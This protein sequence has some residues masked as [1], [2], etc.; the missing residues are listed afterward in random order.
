MTFT[1]KQASGRSNIGIIRM[2]AITAFRRHGLVVGRVDHTTLASESGAH[3]PLDNLVARCNLAGRPMWDDVITEH[4]RT[5]VEATQVGNPADLPDEEFYPRLRERVLAPQ[6]LDQHREF[7]YNYLRPLIAAEP[8]GLQRGLCLS[9]PG[10]ALT[11][12]DSHVTP[13]DVEAAW[14]TGR[15]NTA[16][17]TFDTFEALFKD[18]VHVAVLRGNSIFLASKVA[19]MQTMADQ[20][21]GDSPNGVLF[22]IPSGYEIDCHLPTDA[23]TALHAA[24]IMKTL[25]TTL[26]GSEPAP[27]SSQVFFWRAGRI[28][29]VSPGRPRGQFA[30]LL[31]ELTAG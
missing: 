20:Y 28:E 6:M 4:V 1:T 16:A 24:E 12:A 19:D 13:R 9:F 21:F 30:H 10:H 26:Y 31:A 11:L 27:L 17:V 2:K 25:A 18:D 14:A 7:G 22:T 15:V 5:M 3:F 29:L 8:N 23:G